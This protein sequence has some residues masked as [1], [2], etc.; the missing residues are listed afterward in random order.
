[1]RIMDYN[2]VVRDLNGLNHQTF[3]AKV[4]EA[5]SVVPAESRVHPDKPG[6]VGMY[7]DCLLYTSRCV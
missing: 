3:V 7:L 2:R 6:V 4:A 5:F 1:M